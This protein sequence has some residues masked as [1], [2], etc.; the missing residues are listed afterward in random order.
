MMGIHPSPSRITRSRVRGVSVPENQTGMPPGWT[1]LGS[2][3]IFSKR[4]VSE[5]KCA[6]LSPPE[7]AARGDRIVQ[8][9]AATAVVEL[10]GVELLLLP[11]GPHAQVEPPS[12]QHVE[13]RGG[14][15][16][17]RRGAQRRD[18]DP[19][20]QPYASGRT[21]DR[22]EHGQRFQP[23]CVDRQR[24]ASPAVAIGPVAHHQVVGHHD[25]VD[26]GV[27]RHSR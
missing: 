8:Q 14:L 22:R 23:R 12:G 7:R 17:E 13:G 18:E 6:G 26:A 4:I 24:E 21:R 27:L 2:H 20:R 16:E 11:T 15:G 1:G 5:S 10:H 19:G 3:Q 9:P 25:R